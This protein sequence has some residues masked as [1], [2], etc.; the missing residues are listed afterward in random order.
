MGR[1]S[2]LQLPK[3]SSF[4]QGLKTALSTQDGPRCVERW[5]AAWP[6]SSAVSRVGGWVRVPQSSQSLLWFLCATPTASFLGDPRSL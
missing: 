3:V 4:V 1:V 2:A 6:L 5:L